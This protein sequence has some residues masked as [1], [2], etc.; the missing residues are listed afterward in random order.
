M[1]LK[2]LLLVNKG[3]KRLNTGYR[4]LADMSNNQGIWKRFEVDF[5]DF[6]APKL[7]EA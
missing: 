6:T 1:G 4:G 7:P 5:A 3:V 2:N